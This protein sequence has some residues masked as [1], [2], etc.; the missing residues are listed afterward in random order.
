[1]RRVSQEENSLRD[2]GGR[3]QLR[4]LPAPAVHLYL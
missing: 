1:M 2:E 3:G 4:A